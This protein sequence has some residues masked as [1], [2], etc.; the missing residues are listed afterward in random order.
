MT[1]MANHP[2]IFVPVVR[3]VLPLQPHSS[4]VVVLRLAFPR[5]YLLGCVL[6]LTHMFVLVILHA[7]P[8]HGHVDW[9]DHLCVSKKGAEN[10]KAACIRLFIIISLRVARSARWR[11]RMW[12]SITWSGT[13][14][15]DSSIANA[16]DAFAPCSPPI[17]WATCFAVLN[18]FANSSSPCFCCLNARAC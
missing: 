3:I 17:S 8:A 18:V 14:S 11:V 16:L 2:V 6:Y 10:Q 12:R 9:V 15:S 5:F 13:L 4:H 7:L 1:E